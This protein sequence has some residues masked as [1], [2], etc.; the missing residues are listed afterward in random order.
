MQISVIFLSLL[1]T[2]IMA[3]PTRLFAT[4]SV[5]HHMT[6]HKTWKKPEKFNSESSIDSF[7][8]V[9]KE[10]SFTKNAAGIKDAYQALRI[11]KTVDTDSKTSIEEQIG[12][13]PYLSASAKNL[14]SNMNEN[15]LHGRHTN[16]FFRQ[17]PSDYGNDGQYSFPYPNRKSTSHQNQILRGDDGFN[18]SHR[19]R[20]SFRERNRWPWGNAWTSLLNG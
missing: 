10:S 19:S 14:A 9:V 17:N 2:E 18:H 15:T 8:K 6:F 11:D 20:Q 3:S 1:A 4:R 16:R 12:L 13:L 7:E 5:N